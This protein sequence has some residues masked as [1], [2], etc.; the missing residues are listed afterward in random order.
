VIVEA[1]NLMGYDAMALGETDLQLGEDILRQ[2]IAD[3]HFPVLSA[4]VN[5]QSTSELLTAP[6]VLLEVAGRRVGIIGLT[7]SGSVPATPE[8]PQAPWSATPKPGAD[9][10]Q[11]DGKHIIGSLAVADP[12]VSLAAYAKELQAQTNIIVVLSNLGWEANLRL[13]EMVPGLDLIISAGPGEVVAQPWQAPE[14][15]TLV[16]QC[17]VYP[18][19]RPGELLC[20]VHMHIDSTGTVTEYFGSRTVLNPAFPTDAE[21]RELL[22]SY[23]AQ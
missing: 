23:Q 9:T 6:Y 4:N 20:N 7:G 19:A 14:T 22:R 3:A 17:G 10:S 5:V 12:T 15:G 8:E 1:M 13:A 21:I 11:P 18:Q 16:C 2:R